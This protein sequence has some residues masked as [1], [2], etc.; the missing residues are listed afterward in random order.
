MKRAATWP[1]WSVPAAALAALVIFTIVFEVAT[2][3]ESI[4]IRPEWRGHPSVECT[5]RRR[6]TFY[7]MPLWRSFG[8]WFL[9]MPL[10]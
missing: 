4:L 3:G 8:E 10:S 7:A 9:K 2:K 6:E 1:V 5:P